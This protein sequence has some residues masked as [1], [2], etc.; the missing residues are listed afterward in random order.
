MCSSDLYEAQTK[1]MDVEGKIMM[2]DKEL[3]AAV[4]QNL[5]TMMS[6][7][8]AEV[9]ESQRELE[10]AE[11]GLEQMQAQQQPA[12]PQGQGGQQAPQQAPS[13]GTMNRQPDVQALTGETKPGENNE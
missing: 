1:R 11:S 10:S 6:A 12:Q 7:G 3:Q 13:V 5:M 2:T 9:M 8:N 4:Q